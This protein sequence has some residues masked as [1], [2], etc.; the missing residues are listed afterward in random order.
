MIIRPAHKEEAQQI[1]ELLNLTMLEITYQFIGEE[2]SV[3]ANDFLA[4]FIAREDNQY[5]Y[6]N[7]FVAEEEG[8]LVG[9]ISLYDG[10]YLHQLRQPIWDKIKS[11]RNIDY[12]AEDETQAGEIYL[13]TIAVSPLVQGKGIGKQLLQFAIDEYVEKQNKVIGLLVDNDNP[14][15][16]RLYERMGFRVVKE[17]KI[18]GKIMEHMQYA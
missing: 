18:F 5:S 3:K 1:A 13:D 4:Y 6:Q 17:K 7:I 2:D 12:W 8:T 11:D 16:K 10:A 9:Q 14:N 15:A